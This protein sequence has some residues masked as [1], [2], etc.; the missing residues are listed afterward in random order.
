[1]LLILAGCLLVKTG[2]ADAS[3]GTLEVIVNGEIVSSGDKRKEYKKGEVVVDKCFSSLDKVEVR[4]PSSKGW[5]GSI[6][7]SRDGKRSY[8]P[9]TECS[10]CAS[11]TATTK[12][13]LLVDG[14]GNAAHLFK[15]ACN[16]GATCELHFLTGLP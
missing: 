2:T 14:D 3:D 1:M 8:Q 11:G 9:F 15:T 12:E 5:I 7:V 10:K 16:N 6:S 4:N 13:G